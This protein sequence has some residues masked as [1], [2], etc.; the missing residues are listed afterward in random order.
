MV[1]TEGT[2]YSRWNAIALTRWR[3]DAALDPG[4]SYFLVRD[5]DRGACWSATARPMLGEGES[6]ADFEATVPCL[7]RR[8]QET[9]LETTLAVGADH[10]IELRR[11]RITNLASRRRTLSVTS[12]AELVLAAPASDA[13]HPAF[14]KMFVETE[15]DAA[16]A[17]IVATRR[18][19]APDDA[20][21]WLFHLA[22]VRRQ[23]SG[24]VVRD[25][26]H[27]LHRPRPRRSGAAGDGRRRCAR[28]SR[29]ARARRD[30]RDTRSAHPRSGTHVHDR[31]VHRHRRVARRHPCP[32][33]RLPRSALRRSRA[34]GGE[35]LPVG[36]AAAHRHRRSR[37]APV[38]APRGGIAGGESGPARQ[39]RR[40]RPQRSR[41]GGSLGV[42]HL[43]R[44]SDRTARGDERRSC[45]RRATARRGACVLDRARHRQRSR[46]LGRQRRSRTAGIARC[47]AAGGRRG[48]RHRAHRQAGRHL[49]R[50]RRD[51][52]RRPPHAPAQRRACRRRRRGRRRRRARREAV[53]GRAQG[54]CGGAR[55]LVAA[56]A[57]RA[58][59]PRHPARSTRGHTPAPRLQRLRRLRPRPARV[60]D[61]HVDGTHDAR[62]VDERD[63]ESRF[64][65]LGLGERQRFQLERERARVPADAL[66]ERSGER[67]PWRGALHPR[68]GERS[69]LVA[70]PAADAQRRRIPDAP[71][72]RLQH[73]RA[74]ARRHRI[75]A[76]RL[77]RGRCAGQV[78]RA[79]A[80]QPLRPRP[81][82]LGDGVRRMGARRRAREDADAGRDRGRRRDRRALRAQRLQRRLRG[83]DG[84]LRRRLGQRRVRRLRRPRR[85]LRPARDARRTGRRSRGHALRTRR[86]RSRSVRRASRRGRSRAR[87]R[88]R[89]RVPARRRPNRGRGA[90]LRAPL[91]RKRRR[92]RCARGRARP[93]ERHPGR[94]PRAHSRSG[95][96]CARERLAA[97]PAAGLAPLGADGV[98]PVER[99]VRL[100]R[101][102]AGRDGARARRTRAHPRAPAARG[103]TTVRRRRRSALVAPAFGQRR[104]HALFRRLP[105][106]AVGDRALRRGH[107]R[108]ERARCELRVPR[109]PRRRRRR[110]FGLRGAAGLGAVRE[111]LRARRARHPARAPLGR[112]M[113][114]RSW[115]R[116]TGTTA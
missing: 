113:A 81:A 110:G 104:P 20:R 15:I 109:R 25:R 76:L 52:R 94:R 30:R 19:S 45:R 41:P 116:A 101:P 7:R 17:A 39:R 11:L 64:R 51:V 84:V 34:R 18:P 55:C 103:G 115:E 89:G 5:R 58:D 57:G 97:L 96:R 54:R 9:E 50:R 22:A 108:R 67:P 27:A 68:R 106:A 26:P 86:R 72:L 24:R 10:D 40:D 60:R 53:A 71:R 56:I 61:R 80:A 63:R 28:R 29:R 90:R 59:R 92:A 14:S 33:T 78:L 36:R 111:P 85:F 93:L 88:T 102:A 73:L 48:R 91:A 21:R 69:R 43:G 35:P 12:Y 112:R 62:P 99:C 107:G 79:D 70:D 47:R 32:G 1:T 77:G 4:G 16:L 95:S 37:C 100:S 66:V 87:G 82:A 23:R 46:A 98:L 13:A 75:G 49:R 42:G 8:D 44:P 2:G 31:L 6:D 3:E 114:C 38:R 83:A 65:H 105:L 74:R